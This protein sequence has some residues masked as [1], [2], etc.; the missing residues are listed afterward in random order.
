MKNLCVKCI[1]RS[2]IRKWWIHII[3]FIVFILSFLDGATYTVTVAAPDA[4]VPPTLRFFMNAANANPGPD[5]ILFNIPGT[6]PH[7]IMPDSQLPVLTDQAGVIIDGL[8]QPGAT[9]GGNPPAS[10]NLMIVLDGTNAGAVHGIWIV[11]SYNTIQGL[12]VQN[13]EQDGIRMQASVDTTQYNYVYCNFVGTDQTGNFVQG[14]GWNQQGLWAGIYVICTPMNLGFAYFNVI[15]RNLASGNYAEGIGIGSC[16]P[17]DVAFNSVLANYVGTDVGG[18]VDLGNIH[19]GV[20]IGEGAH[21]NVVD[22]NLISGNDFEGVCIV[23]Y[24]EAM[25]PV[26]TDANTVANNTIGLDVSLAPLPNTY[27][28]VSIG[29]YGAGLV[30][31]WYQGG[32]ARDNMISTNI[33]A[34]NGRNGVLVWEHFS[35]NANADFNPITQ[36]SMYNNT[37]LGIDLG[38]DGVTANDANDP[39]AGPNQE[40]NFPVITSAVETAGQTTISGNLDIDTDPTQAMVEVFRVSSDPSGYGEGQTYLGTANPN[41][42]GNWTVVVPGLVA[43]DTV[44]ATTTDINFNTSEFAQN[45]VVVTGIEENTSVIPQR[46]ELGQNQPNPFTHTTAIHFALP[47]KGDLTLRVYD[48]SGRSVA[49][50]AYGQYTAGYHT[51]QWNGRDERGRRVNPGVYIYTLNAGEFRDMRKMVVTR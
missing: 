49:V 12:V 17:G 23:G 24:A 13:F 47:I 28:G 11:S 50:L 14:N 20:Y 30:P 35:N 21:D 4:N 51:T 9:A 19:D 34:H 37:L 38:D 5:T 16:P 45:F 31:P 10:A 48:V 3:V 41:A 32:Y 7:V 40:V 43:G 18:T 22:G 26:F 46:Y 8:S 42:S 33:I 27:D 2:P 25:P 36:N 39:D 6:G 15:D 29:I 44:T 1:S